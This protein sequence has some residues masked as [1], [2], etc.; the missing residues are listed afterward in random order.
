MHP[1]EIR[2]Y[3]WSKADYWS[4]RNSKSIQCPWCPMTWKN[5]QTLN[6]LHLR[7]VSYTLYLT[8][9][10][11]HISSCTFHLAHSSYTLNCNPH[12]MTRRNNSD[13][14]STNCNLHIAYISQTYFKELSGNLIEEISNMDKKNQTKLKGV[15]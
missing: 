6:T 11:L 13:K 9:F 5:D 15:E 7:N 10:I 12:T 2:P 4:L 3:R 14:K 1:H 8:Y